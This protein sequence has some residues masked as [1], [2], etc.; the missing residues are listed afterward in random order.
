MQVKKIKGE[1]TTLGLSRK[2]QHIGIRNTET[3]IQDCIF[4]ETQKD[5]K[6]GDTIVLDESTRKEISYKIEKNKDVYFGVIFPNEKKFN[7]NKWVVNLI[8]QELAEFVI[9]S[10]VIHWGDSTYVNLIRNYKDEDL[11]YLFSSSFNW[12]E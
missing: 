12:S 8:A 2:G 1:L 10:Q 5:L 6:V 4:Y 3:T 9:V 11:D 7:K